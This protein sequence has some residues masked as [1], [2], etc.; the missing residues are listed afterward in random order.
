MSRTA[1]RILSTRPSSASRWSVLAAILSFY[2]DAATLVSVAIALPV[3]RD[4]YRLDVWQVGVLS[5]GLTFAVALGALTGGWLADRL[6]RGRVFTG[7]LVV[8]VAG[9]ALV[10]SAPNGLVLTG[11]VV[12]LGVAT[13]CDVPVALAVVA[14]AAHGTRM[15]RLTGITQVV[16]T[17]AILVTFGLGIAFS[18]QGVRGTRVLVVHLALLAVATLGLRLWLMARHPAPDAP[19]GLPPHRTR[20]GPVRLLQTDPAVRL[21]LLLVG[22]FFV[23]S[24]VATTT[25]G[26][27]LTYFLVT[28]SGLDQKSATILTS[29]TVALALVMA[30]L[31]ARLSDSRWRDRLFVIAVVAQV[32]AFGTGAVTGG[33]TLGAMLAVALLYSLSSVFAGEAIYKVWAQLLFPDDLRATTL[34]ATYGVA[35]LVA[36]LFLIVVPSL[37]SMSPALLMAV[38]TGCVLASGSLGLVITRHSA[39]AGRLHSVSA[40]Y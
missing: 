34:G 29:T 12:L 6:G 13:G 37:I 26:A 2:L 4:V 16:W 3:W 14:D 32:A 39:L 20:G 11:G 17:S 24:N 19:P 21:P 38:L 28:V 9:T 30:V 27:Y 1:S 18:G 23:F 35:R 33:A 36:A 22:G 8:F 31:F 10:G 5:G 40:R 7:D 15:I 25:V